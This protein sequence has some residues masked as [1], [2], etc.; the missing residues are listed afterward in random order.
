MERKSGE[1]A[2]T[3]NRAVQIFAM[4]VYVTVLNQLPQTH[5][6][7]HPP[8]FVQY[9]NYRSYSFLW[10][11]YYKL[12]YQCLMD[13]FNLSESSYERRA[14]RLPSRFYVFF[15]FQ[16]KAHIA[17]AFEDNVI[18]QIYRCFS[19]EHVIQLDKYILLAH[20]QEASPVLSSS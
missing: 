18:L 7:K 12:F 14:Q 15:H 9:F 13:A 11:H 19:F 5:V 16:F 2:H 6:R 20:L 4:P 8:Y 10:S 1:R 17:Y 3:E